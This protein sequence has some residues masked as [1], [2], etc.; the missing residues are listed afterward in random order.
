MKL[1]DLNTIVLESV[2][3]STN[4]FEMWA[5][6]LNRVDAK[7]ICE[8]G[9]WKGD[10]AKYLLDHINKIE[11]YIFVDPWRNLPSWNKPAN[12]SNEEF[13]DIRQEALDKNKQ[14]A[15]KIN[16]LRMTTKEAGAKLEDEALS[17]T[18]IDG[19]HTLR[20]ITIDL[21]VIYP[22]TKSNGLIGGDDFTKNIWQHS[23]RYDPTEVFP[24]AL[25]FAEAKNC[26][27]FTLP[28]NQ[29]LIFKNDHF[30]VFDYGG[31]AKLT[32]RNIYSQPRLPTF[33][34][35]IPHSIKQIIKKIL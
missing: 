27:I 17:Y 4:R 28:Y 35:F 5:Y 25:Y 8:V 34:K 2:Q 19:D 11:N 7:N 21:N 31:Y 14:Y 16:E 26:T 24:Y 23:E 10:Y 29:F 9:V 1:S 30:E 32:P 33:R 15:S 3:K 13:E 12:R 6:I 20:G 22:K 18:Y